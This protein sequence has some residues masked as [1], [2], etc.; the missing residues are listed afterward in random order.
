MNFS[1]Y[2]YY[3]LCSLSIPCCPFL[4]P[5]PTLNGPFPP[6]CGTPRLIHMHTQNTHNP[7]TLLRIRIQQKK[8]K[9][10]YA[11]FPEEHRCKIPQ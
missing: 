2:A 1:I 9:K 4:L 7:H 8:K 10:R 3:I 11:Q 5:L 6:P